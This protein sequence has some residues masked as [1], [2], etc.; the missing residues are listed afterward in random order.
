MDK[1]RTFKHSVPINTCKVCK[2]EMAVSFATEVGVKF[3]A[4]GTG[5]CVEC[6]DNTRANE[7]KKIQRLIRGAVVVG[8]EAAFGM[9]GDLFRIWLK[10]KN[11]KTYTVEKYNGALTI[12]EDKKEGNDE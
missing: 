9:Y 10:A 5:M 6:R 3:E 12:E 7:R 2:G 1:H 11:G 4:N 8:S